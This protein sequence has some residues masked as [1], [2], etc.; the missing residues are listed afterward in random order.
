MNPDTTVLLVGA[1]DEA[2]QK[3]RQLGLHVLLLQHP[4]KFSDEQE[5]LADHTR[6]L[7]YTDWAEVRPVAEELKASPGF[8]A[9]LSLTEAGLENAGRIN[10]LFGL[11]GTGFEVAH[12]I[13]DKGAMRLHLAGLDPAAPAAALLLKREDLDV[14]AGRHGYPFVV[15]PTDG[16]A[17]LGVFR[18]AGPEDADRVWAEVERLRGTRTDRVSTLFVLRDFLMEEY[19]DGPEFSV[20]SFSFA[21]RHVVVAITEKFVDPRHF[22]ELGHAVPARLEA[23]A[24]QQVRKCVRRFLDL[25]GIRDGVCHTEVRIGARGPA[26]IE[27]H[28]RIAG[29]AITDLVRGA[30]GIDLVAHALGWPFGLVPELPDSPEAHAGAST[31]FLVGEAGRVE[32][33]S[34]VEEVRGQPDVLDVRLSAGPGDTVRDLKDNW[35]RLGLVAVTGPDTTSA[36]LRGAEL[37]RDTLEIRIARTDGGSARARVAG[38]EALTQDTGDAA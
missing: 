10:D 5:R 16:T 24:A 3:A 14:F 18:V 38:R 36:I 30:Y 27:S 1:N 26:I 17:S 6:V 15:K 8:G 4:S 22:A 11:G 34:G 21:G 7:D 9:A 29:D 37:I 13:R 33:V 25:V 12:R 32:S 20:E 28:N 19:V 31:R 35:D 23:D 2:V